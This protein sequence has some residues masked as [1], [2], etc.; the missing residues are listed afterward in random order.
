MHKTAH[1]PHIKSPAPGCLRRG[2]M[3]PAL[4]TGSEGVTAVARSLQDCRAI[5]IPYH[6]MPPPTLAMQCHSETRSFNLYCAM[7]C[8]CH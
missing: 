5:T 8:Q 3:T 1:P 6:T 2:G 4:Y 7:P